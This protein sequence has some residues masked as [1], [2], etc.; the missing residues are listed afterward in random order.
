MLIVSIVLSLSLV[1]K[2]HNC[3]L[4]GMSHFL[5]PGLHEPQLP[6]ESSVTLLSFIVGERRRCALQVSGV[7]RLQKN[8]AYFTQT[9]TAK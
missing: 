6:V 9:T 5:K 8:K 2:N 1:Y 7:A 4:S 3:K